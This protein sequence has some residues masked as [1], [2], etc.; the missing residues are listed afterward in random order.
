V[1]GFCD[2]RIISDLEKGLRSE[3]E[4]TANLF[5]VFNCYVMAWICWPNIA[6]QISDIELWVNWE[7][8][9]GT[10]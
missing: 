9:T 3:V 1:G 4:K 7:G 6:A 10:L 5:I 8:V 2:F